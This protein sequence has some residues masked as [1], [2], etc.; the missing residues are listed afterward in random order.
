M[1]ITQN[2]KTTAME[3]VRKGQTMLIAVWNWFSLPFENT[4]TPQSRPFRCKTLEE[5]CRRS[6]ATEGPPWH[7]VRG[8]PLWNGTAKL[9][10]ECRFLVQAGGP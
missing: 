9:T 4:R 7:L 6:D 8:G 1:R 10:A 2:K 3:R 5:L